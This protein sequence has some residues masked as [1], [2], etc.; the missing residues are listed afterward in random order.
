MPKESILFFGALIFML[1]PSKMK[2]FH[3]F[4]SIMDMDVVF[5][6]ISQI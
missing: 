6:L 1:K 2:R 4:G 5:K 3:H